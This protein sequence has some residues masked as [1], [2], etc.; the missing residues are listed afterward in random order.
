MFQRVVKL[1]P[2]NF[3]GYS[4]LG[5]LLVVEGKYADSIQVLK[6]SLEIRPTLEAYSNL[7]TAFFGLRR[8]GD[9]AE[10]YQ[11][12][13]K[14]DDRDSLIWGN[15]GDAL[16]WTPGRR[17]EA[18]AAYRKAAV[19]ATSKLQVN[20]RD[21]ILLAFRAT[22]NAMAGN[23]REA[24]SDLQHARQLMPADPEVN[25][26]AA[27]VYN[28]L[29]DTQRCLAALEKAVAAGYPASAIRDT[30]D[31]DHLRDNPRVQQLLGNKRP[32]QRPT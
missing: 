8:F 20:Q 12:G 15:L 9:A 17:D 6:H 24:L 29:G 19:L 22:Y 11:Q 21:S 23:K 14:L 10:M 13:L 31:F 5:G 27:L 16:Y 18:A 28:H 2:E 25:F 32:A 4:T 30:P 1:A 3:E 26:R 7:G